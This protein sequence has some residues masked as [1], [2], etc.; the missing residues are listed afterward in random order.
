[1]L[2][3]NEVRPGAFKIIILMTDGKPNERLQDTLIE[4]QRAKDERIRIIPIG[5][6]N[7]IDLDLLRLVA[8]NPSDVITTPNFNSLTSQVA[9]IVSLACGTPT[10]PPVTGKILTFVNSSKIIHKSI[11]FVD[12]FKMVFLVMLRKIHFFHF[13]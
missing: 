2:S 9:N 5:V 1:M 13:K 6:T 11:D 3:P 7:A 8:N 10:P 12:K 4:A